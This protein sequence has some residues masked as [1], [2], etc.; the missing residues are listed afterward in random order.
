M[1]DHDRLP[2]LEVRHLRLVEALVRHGTL[3]RAAAALHATQSALS[4]Q[5]SD[6]EDRLG[7]RLFVR[8]P[9]RM[10]PTAAAERLAETARR[11]LGELSAAEAEARALQGDAPV[12]VRLA[13]GCYTCYHWLPR[14]LIELR[15][16]FPTIDVQVAADYTRRPIEGLLDRAV[17]LAIVGDRVSHAALW[18]EP[19]F[20]DELVLLVPAGHRL[21]G[22]SYVSPAQLARETLVTY[23]V[24]PTE[25]TVFTDFLSPAR[26]RPK[27]V[28]RMELTEAI[29]EM[30]RADLGVA[31][32]ARWAAAPYL[33][34]G[35]LASLALTRR[36]YRREWLAVMRRE[37]RRQP[38]LQTL[39]QLLRG[40][41]L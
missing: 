29:V 31:C 5:L 32:L 16:R 22:R 11:V 12:R 8:Q 39:V 6:L 28:I 34:D 10:A 24:P 3:T 33:R 20:T 26:V 1:N 36:G 35:R 38:P 13:T 19:L 7:L 2:A 4:H 25:L 27:A 17:D 14:R 23:N 9:R 37:D 15:R 40:E 41:P 21:A 18:K 30:V